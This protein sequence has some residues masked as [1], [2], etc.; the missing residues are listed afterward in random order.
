M[1]GT[2]TIKQ[3]QE[4]MWQSLP[5]RRVAAGR[6]VVDDVSILAIQFWPV[7][8]LCQAAP[9]SREE[10]VARADLRS[11][12]YR[13]LVL[14]YGLERAEA[15]RLLGLDSVVSHLL[16]NMCDWWRRRKD[17]RAKLIIW[18]RKWRDDV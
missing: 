6:E 14:V 8:E 15:L 9:R 11:D 13:L 7:E 2:S 4:Y 16:D 1:S 10:F 18:R 3:F 12:I 5:A 17:N